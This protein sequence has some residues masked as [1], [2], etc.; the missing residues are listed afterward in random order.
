LEATGEQ[1]ALSEVGAEIMQ[2]D[3]GPLVRRLEGAL[4][5]AII[6]VFPS[7]KKADAAVRV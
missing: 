3:P 5:L 4:A 1:P 2:S 7:E 6:S